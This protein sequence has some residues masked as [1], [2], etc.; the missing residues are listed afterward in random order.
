[1]QRLIRAKSG[2]FSPLILLRTAGCASKVSSALKTEKKSE[3]Q[4]M[5]RDVEARRVAEHSVTG[6]RYGGRGGRY[7]PQLKPEC[8]I[9]SDRSE[10]IQSEREREREI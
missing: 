3:E 4:G 5:N 9:T 7:T 8:V 10:S 6:I 2:T 1:M